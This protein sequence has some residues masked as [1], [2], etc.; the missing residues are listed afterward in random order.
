MIPFKRALPT[1]PHATPLCVAHKDR[2][3]GKAF[4]MTRAE[5]TRL[6]ANGEDPHL[7][8]GIAQSRGPSPR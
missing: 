4:P 7:V 1:V 6:I 2:Q 8:A 3:F 5:A